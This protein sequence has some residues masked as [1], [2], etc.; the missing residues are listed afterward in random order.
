MPGSHRHLRLCLN[1][2]MPWCDAGDHSSDMLHAKCS[3][4]KLPPLALDLKQLSGTWQSRHLDICVSGQA[5]RFCP[6]APVTVREATEDTQ[7][8]GYKIPRG[9]RMRVNI[10]GLHHD[11]KLFPNAADFKPERFIDDP[12]LVKSKA[13]LPFGAGPHNCVG[14]VHAATQQCMFHVHARQR[15][16]AICTLVM[17]ACV[18]RYRF[19][20]EEALV[21][22]VNLYSKY[23][24]R[25]SDYH[26]P[27]GD[28]HIRV[29]LTMAPEKGIN[30][31]AVPRVQ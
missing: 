14:C 2:H 28:L 27:C 8:G 7:L 26:H 16:S 3:L 31:V 17:P 6:V 29:R 21:M 5:M 30:V 10:Y 18:R 13:Y 9:T 4:C 23:T 22:L 25:L 15:S 20:L 12:D 24:F 11:S 19:A 1:G